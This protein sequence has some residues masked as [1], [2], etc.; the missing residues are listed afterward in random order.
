MGQGFSL[1]TLSAAS[2]NI[3][4]PEL[5]ELT[6]EKTLN[7]GRFMK[8]I[9]ARNQQGFVFVKAI[10]KP[11]PQFELGK[12]VKRLIRE[13][14]ILVTLPNTIGYR[15]VLETVTSGFLVR[16]YLH[17]SL[18]DRMSTRPFLEVIEKK[19][20][21]FQLLCAVRDSHAQNIH[22]GDIKTENVLVTSWNWLYLC[23]FSSIYKPVYLPE[24]NPADFS[25]YFDTS[26]RR[27]CYLA[28]ERFVSDGDGIERSPLNW[29]MDIFSVGCVIAELFLEGPIFSLS[30]LFKYR[31][32]D[33]NPEHTHL[34][35]IEDAEVRNMILTMIKLN[36][37]D[38]YSAEEYLNFY[39]DKIF[40]RYFYH[41]LH[42][43]LWT[44][45]DPSSGRKTISIETSN[46]G[47]TDGKIESVFSDFDKISYLLGHNSTNSNQTQIF[48]NSICLSNLFATKS[49][50]RAAAL[51][52]PV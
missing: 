24:D 39:Q 2:A 25:F 7:S 22:H 40:P 48:E 12:Y 15:K 43:Y 18:Y 35:R 13:R 4:V 29:A 47:E 5:S 46:D 11:Y 17:S 36:P 10:V 28:P 52:T 23:D 6:H 31:A 50:C 8:S 21:A 3:D 9:R 42:Q 41:F 27:T 26:G 37:E 51:A 49:E 33:Y 1:T 19:W 14:D 32:G 30:H 38:R 16:Q 34:A 44:M 45:T 20:L